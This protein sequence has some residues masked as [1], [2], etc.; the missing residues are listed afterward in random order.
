MVTTAAY[1]WF[2]RESGVDPEVEWSGFDLDKLGAWTN[3]DPERLDRYPQAFRA[4]AAWQ[5]GL[6]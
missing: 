1:T 2:K 5:K 3:D 6:T 4:G